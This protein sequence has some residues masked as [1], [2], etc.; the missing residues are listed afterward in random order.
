MTGPAVVSIGLAVVGSGLALGWWARG[1]RTL[2]AAAGAG[3]VLVL[4]LLAA[5]LVADAARPVGAAPWQHWL[6]LG[7]TGLAGVV[8]GGAI[9]V[10]VLT[11]ADRRSGRDSRPATTGSLRGG[12]WIGVL[13]RLGIFASLTAGYPTAVVVILAIKG[14][15]RYPELRAGPHAGIAERFIIGTFTSM[16]AAAGAAGMAQLL[17]G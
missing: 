14:L 16:L 11:V 1:P 13:E 7:T 15:A 10:A 9:T 12:A 4:L 17:L 3:T 5:A 8:G 2:R 6:V